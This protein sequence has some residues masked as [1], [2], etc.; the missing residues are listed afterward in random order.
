MITNSLTTRLVTCRTAAN[1]SNDYRVALSTQIT[2][3]K[4]ATEEKIL[5]FTPKKKK[6]KFQN[7]IPV[8]H[9][10]TVPEIISVVQHV[11]YYSDKKQTRHTAH[12]G[13]NVLNSTRGSEIT[14]RTVT[15][16]TWLTLKSR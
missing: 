12:T 1:Y 10:Q 7:E 9:T 5:N 14:G 6:C 11:Q 8:T 15:F 13:Q 4:T 3:L 16:L 2:N